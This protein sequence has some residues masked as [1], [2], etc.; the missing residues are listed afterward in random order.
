MLSAIRPPPR[1]TLFPYTTLFRSRAARAARRCDAARSRRTSRRS[2]ARSA[3]RSRTCS[4]RG[5]TRSASPAPSRAATSRSARGDRKSTRLNSSHSQI[6]YAVFCMK[7]RRRPGCHAVSDPTPAEIH[8]LSLHDALPISRSPSGSAMRRRTKSPNVAP[9]RRSISSA[10]TYMLDEGWYSK[11]EPGSQPSRH[12]A[13]R[14]RRSEEHT[15]ELQSQSNLVCRL[16]HEKTTEARLSCCQRSDP[17]RDPHSFPT[18]RSSDLAQPERLGDATPHEV[19]E[20]RAGA[21]LDQLG[22]HVHARR[23]VVLEARARLPAEPPRREAREE[24]GRAH[25]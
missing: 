1:S 14:A 5:G 13:K 21:P 4:T 6:S 20:R 2:A 10:I 8:T 19:A 22:D 24:I 17:R 12:V 9:E 15:S 18:R 25:V 11:R 7:K 3:R 16:L 23:G